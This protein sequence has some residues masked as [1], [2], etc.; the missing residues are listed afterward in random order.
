MREAKIF[1]VAAGEVGWFEVSPHK[2]HVFQSMDDL[3]A[4]YDFVIIGGG[5]AGI[6][7][8]F[9]LAELRPDA[10]IAVFEA[11]RVG[12]GDSG[13]NAGFLIDV[14]H[15]FGEP[16]VSVDDHKWRLRLNNIVINRMRKIKDD[17]N[18]QCDWD[19][20]GKYL[21]T[22]EKRYIKNL[23]GAA[24]VLE[25]LG[26]PHK[27]LS[28]HELPE[29]LGTGYYEQAL[30]TT[31]TVLINPADVIRALATAL[32]E[33]VSVFERTPV[34]QVNEGNPAQVRLVNGRVLSADKVLMLSSVFVE[35]FGASKGKMTPVNSFGAFTRR[36]TENEMAGFKGV[37]PWGCTSGHP[38]GTT[39]RLTTDNR[40]FVRNGFTF[41][42]S[43]C[44]S[45]QR[46]QASRKKLRKAFEARFPQLK[47]VNFE[48]VYGGMIPMT[49]NGES[50]FTK[51][52][53]S[54]FAGSVGDGAGLTRSSMLGVY[55]AEW[56]CD[57]DSEELEY[58]KKTNKPSWC[59][60]EPFKTI[61]A[62]VR[63]AFED[64]AAM[65]DV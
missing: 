25:A 13:R 2:N 12:L 42:S 30:Y 24:G 3:E 5:F 22:R 1:P 43:L 62:T 40:I 28:K 58:L 51:L 4:S 47:H 60:P 53:R 54:V 63:L 44:T 34:L 46:I 27:M 26:E 29:L 37:A 45:P 49:L 52:H 38:A 23:E 7:A 18:I 56:A 19:E 32:P 14:P 17:N 21:A 20:S 36:L 65:G 15:S 59:P 57:V 31:G 9:R 16:G 8:A 61:G 10:K 64:L 39:V 11:L 35:Q 41:A 6:N 50:L 33:N 48:F 55:L